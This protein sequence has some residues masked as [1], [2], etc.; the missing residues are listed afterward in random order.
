V[1]QRCALRQRSC[2]TLCTIRSDVIFNDIE[3]VGKREAS[4]FVVWSS[5]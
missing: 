1:S 4:S 5:L 2:E 3:A